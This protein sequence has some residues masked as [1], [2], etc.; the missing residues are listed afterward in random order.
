MFNVF[1]YRV[2]RATSSGGNEG[3]R[4]ACR[5]LRELQGTKMHFF[6]PTNTWLFQVRFVAIQNIIILWSLTLK[7]IQPPR[8]YPLWFK[9]YLSSEKT[10]RDRTRLGVLRISVER[11]H[12]FMLQDKWYLHWRW[13]AADPTITPVCSIRWREE[14][15]SMLE[16]NKQDP[17]R[18]AAALCMMI[19]K[20]LAKM[21]H[22]PLIRRVLRIK[23]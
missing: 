6:P 22:L 11:K 23:I 12:V 2:K 8:K 18:A 1:G 14:A 7:Y 15:V 4:N 19:M 21:V 16:V 5:K 17:D 10:T 13:A 20:D 9:L 3:S